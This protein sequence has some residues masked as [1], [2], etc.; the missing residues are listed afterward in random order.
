[1]SRLK[2]YDSGAIWIKARLFINR[3]LDADRDF[4]ESA[5][6]ACSAL[7]LLGKSALSR[8]NPALIAMPTDDGR[9]LLIASGVLDD[10]DGFLTVQAKTIWSRAAKA[11]RQ[12]NADEARELSIGRNA[13]IH[14]AALGFEI[15]SPAEWWPRYWAQ[16]NVLIAHCGETLEDFVGEARAR[17]VQAHLETNRANLD[18]RSQA[19]LDNAKL[20]LRLHQSHSLTGPMQRQWALFSPGYER[21][22]TDIDCPACD[23][24]ATVGGSEIASREVLYDPDPEAFEPTSVTLDVWTTSLWCN[25]CHLELNDVDLLD[26]VGVSSGFR[27]EVG[28]DEVDDLYEPEYNNE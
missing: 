24:V 10:Y 1:M 8:I 20:L 12:F 15:F 9:S 27:L 13:Y 5:F 28:L 25:T 16:A 14:S 22:T 23:G 19:L 3:A 2:P 21:Y 26:A 11:F 18:R 17:D 4:H 7:E 6:W